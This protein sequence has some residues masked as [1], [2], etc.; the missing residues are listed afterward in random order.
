VGL[1]VVELPV[2]LQRAVEL[3]CFSELPA[4]LVAI[5]GGLVVIVAMLLVVVLWWLDAESW[6]AA[7][8]QFAPVRPVAYYPLP[9]RQEL[10]LLLDP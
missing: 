1:P 4:V 8:G 6:S 2:E 3:L 10:G 5:A 9:H 7:A